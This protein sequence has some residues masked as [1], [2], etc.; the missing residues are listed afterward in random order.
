MTNQ[1]T[2]KTQ[3]IILT[4]AE[5][6]KC[7]DIKDKQQGL[8]NKRATTLLLINV[9]NTYT[10]AA[11]QTGL[12]IGQVRYL[13]T[14][15]KNKG[16]ALFDIDSKAPAKKAPAKKAPVKKATTKKA[17]AKKAPVKKAVTKKAPAKKAPVKK[18]VTKKA[19]AKKVEL[20]L[21]NSEESDEEPSVKANEKIK[22]K[23]SKKNKKDSK[24]KDK[25]NKKESKKKDKKKKGK[26]KKSK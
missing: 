20:D 23:K 16:I 14:A 12:T 7:N 24:K 19:P 11:E 17:P 13:V 21:S 26:K 22:D 2:S 5:I 6:K 4:N 3:P 9:G 15:Y 8:A 18:A 10:Q 1:T 25:K